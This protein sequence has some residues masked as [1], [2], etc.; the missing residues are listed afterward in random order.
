MTLPWVQVTANSTTTIS[1]S[2]D[3]SKAVIVK[4]RMQHFYAMFHPRNECCFGLVWFIS[5]YDI[6]ISLGYLISD[7]IF[8]IS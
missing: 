8:R 6:S 5:L 3:F 4:K 7:K 2:V 1:F